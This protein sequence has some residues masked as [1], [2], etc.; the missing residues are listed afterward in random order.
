MI[1]LFNKEIIIILLSTA[2]DIQKWEYQ[3]LGPFLS[4]NLGTTISP[5]IVTVDALKPFIVENTKQEPPVLPYLQHNDNFN[6]DINFHVLLTR[7]LHK[8]LF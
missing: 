7:K 3:P 6:F 5:W 4:K 2:R 1:S 8:I